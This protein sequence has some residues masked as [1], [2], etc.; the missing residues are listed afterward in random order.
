MP[1]Y[2][3]GDRVRVNKDIAL[4]K[5]DTLMHMSD[6]EAQCYLYYK[7]KSYAGQVVTIDRVYY[8]NRDSCWCYQIAEDHG[9]DFWV[10]EMFESLSEPPMSDV[11]LDILMEV[12]SI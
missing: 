9:R 5:D 3:P 4:Y 12:L 2:N 6:N 1:K 7:H 8:F 11:N 10:D